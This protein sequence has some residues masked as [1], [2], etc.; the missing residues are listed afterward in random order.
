MIFTCQSTPLI[1]FKYL[2]LFSYDP[3]THL[4]RICVL[5]GV[6]AFAIGSLETPAH[7]FFRFN[8]LIKL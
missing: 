6:S 1:P 2:F 3:I 5:L 7:Q 4:L 8:L